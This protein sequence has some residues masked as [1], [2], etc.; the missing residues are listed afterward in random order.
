MAAMILL[1]SDAYCNGVKNLKVFGDSQ[2]CINFMNGDYKAKNV[3]MLDYFTAAKT[4]SQRFARITFQHIE[5]TY[6][7]EAD[8]LAREGALRRKSE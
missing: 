3:S 5:R 6:N 4:I 1:I 8:K 7:F 2:L